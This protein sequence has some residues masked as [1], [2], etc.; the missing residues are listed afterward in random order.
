MGVID[1]DGGARRRGCHAFDAAM[2]AGQAIDHA[3]T[4]MRR[5]FALADD[6]AEGCQQ[7]FRLEQAGH[8]ERHV[9][10]LAEDVERQLLAGGQ[11]LLAEDPEIARSCGRR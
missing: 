8:R 4:T 3:Q 2:D 7:I 10:A 6:E 9:I 1:I 5:F 11:R